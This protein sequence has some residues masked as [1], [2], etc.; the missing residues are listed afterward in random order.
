M[1]WG[2][3][4]HRH[5]R[6][7]LQPA[8][9]PLPRHRPGDPAGRQRRLRPRLLTDDR[10]SARRRPH[11]ARGPRAVLP[12]SRP[13]QPDRHRAAPQQRPAH[14]GRHGAFRH[15]PPADLRVPG[16][17]PALARQSAPPVQGHP[18]AAP[19]PRRPAAVHRSCRPHRVGSAARLVPHRAARRGR[20]V[21]A[22]G[23]APAGHRRARALRCVPRRPG[24]TAWS[25]RPTRPGTRSPR[26]GPRASRP[27]SPIPASA[28][29][30]SRRITA[31]PFGCST[32]CSAT[33]RKR[34]APRSAGSASNAAAP[35]S[36]TR[37]S[38]AAGSARSPSGGDS[39]T[40]RTTTGPSAART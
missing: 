3:R 27:T 35:T 28:P 34:W 18:A 14:R 16:R 31:S 37:A 32:C 39:V 5:A 9:R 26:A 13:R 6:G 38:V 30:P 12:P 1:V 19:R 17:R 15:L 21:R 36:R 25:R 4:R 29:S 7:H 8:R 11:P 40:R 24:P 22:G 23:A 20:P 10:P 33:S 2:G